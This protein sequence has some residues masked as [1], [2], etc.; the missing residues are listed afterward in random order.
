MSK[1]LFLPTYYA[2]RIGLGSFSSDAKQ[3]RAAGV[4]TDELVDADSVVGKKR[5]FKQQMRENVK[6]TRLEGLTIAQLRAL[7][8]SCPSISRSLSLPQLQEMA[9]K[10]LSE[11]SDEIPDSAPPKKKPKK[12]PA[13]PRKKK[14]P[15]ETVEG[16]IKKYQA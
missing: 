6:G 13:A 14:Q 15:P 4:A 16:C 11:L 10:R 2:C 3:T 7:L 5:A 9:L 1:L 8:S 12:N